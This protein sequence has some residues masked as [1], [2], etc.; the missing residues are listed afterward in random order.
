MDS[1]AG[2]ADAEGEIDGDGTVQPPLTSVLR[3]LERVDHSPPPAMHIKGLDSEIKDSSH[4]SM[5]SKFV[6]ST[7]LNPPV[8]N[9]TLRQKASR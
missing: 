4:T 8:T 2:V 5:A 6:A 3:T 1:G 7:K 9:R